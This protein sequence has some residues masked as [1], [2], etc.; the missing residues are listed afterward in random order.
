MF[1]IIGMWNVAGA[2]IKK[3][4]GHAANFTTMLKFS[5]HLRGEICS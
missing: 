5:A 2:E 3:A 4:A 1:F